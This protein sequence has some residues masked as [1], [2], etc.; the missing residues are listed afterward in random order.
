MGTGKLTYSTSLVN[1]LKG[2]I[3]LQTESK[4]E[5]WYINP[6]DGKRYYLAS[7]EAAYQ[8]MRYLSTGINNKDIQ[9][10]KVTD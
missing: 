6:T 10:I 8:I 7:G 9:K 2:R 4:G 1:K 5:A 3:V